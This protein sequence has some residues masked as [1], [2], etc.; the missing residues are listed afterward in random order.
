M[1]VH[2]ACHLQLGYIVCC[3]LYIKNVTVGRRHMVKYFA[4][5]ALQHLLLDVLA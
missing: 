2:D 1:A 4:I 5:C 3:P